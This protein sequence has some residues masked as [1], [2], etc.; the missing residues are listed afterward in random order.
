MVDLIVLLTFNSKQDSQHSIHFG[1][2]LSVIQHLLLQRSI[3][4]TDIYTRLCAEIIHHLVNTDMTHRRQ[5]A[6]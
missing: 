2:F 3:Q 6:R 4:P 5:I 1:G